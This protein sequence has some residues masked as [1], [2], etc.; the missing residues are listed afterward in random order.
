MQWNINRN[1]KRKSHTQKH[2][3]TEVQKQNDDSYIDIN[4]STQ[5]QTHI[6]PKTKEHK[7]IQREIYIKKAQ[8]HKNTTIV[9]H[10]KIKIYY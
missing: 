4:P 10:R 7:H 2:K 8:S 1:V 5:K 3:K 9:R 6:S